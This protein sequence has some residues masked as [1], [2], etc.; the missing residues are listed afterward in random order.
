MQRGAIDAEA[1]TLALRQKKRKMRVRSS[2]RARRY[3]EKR[4][5]MIWGGAART[6]PS[7]SVTHLRS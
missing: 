3:E 2:E 4:E 7:G 6:R 1:D 5:E